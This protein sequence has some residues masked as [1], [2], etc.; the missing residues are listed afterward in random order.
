MLA[1]LFWPCARLLGA[2]KF[3]GRNPIIAAIALMTIAAAHLTGADAL[4]ARP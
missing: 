2:W 4:I 1:L 3:R